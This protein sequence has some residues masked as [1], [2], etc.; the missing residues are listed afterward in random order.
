METL[1]RSPVPRKGVLLI[2]TS[3][4]NEADLTAGQMEN[5]GLFGKVRGSGGDPRWTKTQEAVRQ[6]QKVQNSISV[7]AQM[8]HEPASKELSPSQSWKHGDSQV[9]TLGLWWILGVEVQAAFRADG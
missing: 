9:K 1:T 5:P 4:E 2:I 7:S 8:R 3:P 6:N